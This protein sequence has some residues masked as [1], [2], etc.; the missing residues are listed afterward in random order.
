M[1]FDVFT[2]LT[3]KIWRQIEKTS[4]F[5]MTMPNRTLEEEKQDK[6]VDTIERCIRQIVKGLSNSKSDFMYSIIMAGEQ[7]SVMP[8]YIE[9]GLKW[10][11]Q[12]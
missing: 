1:E 9:E 3:R 11:A 5:S 12:K 4:N 6:S 8:N 7:Y 10:L 2:K